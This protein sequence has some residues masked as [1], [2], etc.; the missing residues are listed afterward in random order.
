MHLRIHSLGRA[1]ILAGVLVTA[2]PGSGHAA[3]AGDE[4]ADAASA[5]LQA[6]RRKLV[7][8]LARAN[9]EIEQLKK[10]DRGVRDDYRLRARM[11][12]A[13]AIARRLTDIDTKIGATIGAGARPASPTGPR[14]AAP[15]GESAPTDGPAEWEARADILTDQSRRL[16]AEAA[17]LS[18]RVAGVRNRTELRRRAG[19]LEA[20]PFAPLEG[21][22][23]R[24]IVGLPSASPQAPGPS[25][26]DTAPKA[27]SGGGATA[28]TG[29]GGGNNGLV[30]PGTMSAGA[31]SGATAPT[32]VSGGQPAS[33]SPP[34]APA[35]GAESA[36]VGAQA[37][38]RLP[39]PTPVA[40]AG[41]G[42]GV[43]ADNASSLSAQLRD[44]LDPAALATIRKL[45]A[46]GT[47]GASVEA[48]E[49]AAA[50]LRERALRLQAQSNG[51]RERAKI[52]R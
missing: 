41:T 52:A 46:A 21:S 40:P 32:S 47:P 39:G 25:G 50:A 17:A 38:A 15:I 36:P 35:A 9:A 31:G 49:R 24:L 11:A 28:A 29:N 51:L 33:N 45:E 23:R 37:G 4:A 13:E 8:D 34:S 20:D 16:E 2:A 30:A 44:V 12:D 3:F 10:K 42:P 26:A 1:T 5:S 14:P 22:K 43:A 19:Q 27:V 6:E 7:A 18:Q 48:M